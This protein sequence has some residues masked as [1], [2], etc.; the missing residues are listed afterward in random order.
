MLPN[1]IN[2]A[3]ADVPSTSKRARSI[4]SHRESRLRCRQAITNTV[5]FGRPMFSGRSKVRGYN[6]WHPAYVRKCVQ[7]SRAEGTPHT[8]RNGECSAQDA[9]QEPSQRGQAFYRNN[10]VLVPDPQRH[11]NRRGCAAPRLRRAIQY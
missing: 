4:E 3:R 11:S 6:P 9:P 7:R 5:L 8:H 10:G 1:S 2:V